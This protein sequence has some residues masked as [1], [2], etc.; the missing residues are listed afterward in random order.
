MLLISPDLI[1]LLLT[2][3]GIRAQGFN[4]IRGSFSLVF[5]VRSFDWRSL[6]L[7]QAAGGGGGH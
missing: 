5:T 6:H 4:Y 1:W 2:F 7:D 3:V